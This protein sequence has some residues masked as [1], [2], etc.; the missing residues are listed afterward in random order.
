MSDL[1]KEM[2]SVTHARRLLRNIQSKWAQ[3]V[4][5]TAGSQ[6]L[7]VARQ[8]LA[9]RIASATYEEN[10]VRAGVFRY[11]A[12]V[13]RAR[14]D[15]TAEIIER[16]QPGPFE[17]GGYLEFLARQAASVE[18]YLA[19]AGLDPSVESALQHII[20]GTTGEPTSQAFTRQVG[21]AAIIVMSAGM[22]YLMYGL[23]KAVVLSWMPKEAPEGAAVSFSSRIDD[24]RIVLDRDSTPIDL[25]ADT[26]LGWL[27]NGVAR[28]P[29][30][31]APP[32]IY[33]P[34]LDL[35]ANYSE[36]FVIAHEYGHALVDEFKI[37]L[38]WV[39]DAHDISDIDKEF[40]ADVIASI[41]VAASAGEL[42]GVA[43]NMALQGAVLAMK[44]HEIADRAIDLAQGG[45]GTP[46]WESTTHPPFEERA[47]LVEEVYS[48]LVEGVQDSRLNVAAM[49]VPADTAELLWERFSPRLKSELKKGRRLH[50]IWS[51][52]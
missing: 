40:R 16:V 39:S 44:A 27:Y 29:T 5:P 13:E 17:D 36:R 42:D 37:A 33:H 26:L 34:P 10:H 45:D 4:V 28:P 50:P 30:S 14:W 11:P 38:P 49:R 3:G 47:S 48:S 19:A 25:A 18:M 51:R 46:S 12:D 32:P 24:T 22:V 8:R 2:L 15:R 20:F 35:L 21:D 23:A 6:S 43:P 41:V 1:P 9:E 31:T 52:A 7:E